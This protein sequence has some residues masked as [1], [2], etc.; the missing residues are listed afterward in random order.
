MAYIEG[1]K[2]MKIIHFVS[3]IKSGGVEQF[4]YN[5]SFRI[6]KKFDIDEYIIW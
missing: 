3:G 6:N 4:L 5:Y 1:L 2:N